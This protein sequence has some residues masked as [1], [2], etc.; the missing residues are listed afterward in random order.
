MSTPPRQ[1]GAWCVAGPERRSAWLMVGKQQGEETE[2]G[3][4]SREGAQILCQAQQGGT[5]GF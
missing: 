5:G 2:A 3:D 4:G 1:K